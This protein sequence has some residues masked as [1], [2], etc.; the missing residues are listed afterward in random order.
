MNDKLI[1]YVVQPGDNLSKIAQQFYG[2]KGLYPQIKQQNALT[3]DV[4]HPGQKLK[5]KP[6]KTENQQIDETFSIL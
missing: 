2:D 3:N 6:K 5:L 1:E 4:I